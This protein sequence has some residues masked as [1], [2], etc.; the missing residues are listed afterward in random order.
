MPHR[1]K[2]SCLA[3]DYETKGL[4]NSDLIETVILKQSFF[5]LLLLSAYFTDL[6]LVSYPDGH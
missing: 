6:P 2:K 5:F 3:T 4:H 1:E